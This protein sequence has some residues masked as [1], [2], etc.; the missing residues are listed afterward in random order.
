ML[1]KL[2]DLYT[3]AGK[4]A[5]VLLVF[6]ITLVITFEIGIG[7]VAGVLIRNL[8]QEIFN[9]NESFF[10]SFI[11]IFP[12]MIAPLLIDFFWDDIKMFFKTKRKKKR[13]IKKK[14]VEKSL[15]TLKE[16]VAGW[17]TSTFGITPHLD[18]YISLP[19]RLK[20]IMSQK[21]H[22]YS[23]YVRFIRVSENDKWVR[24]FNKYYPLD[25]IYGYN[26]TS[27]ELYFIDGYVVK[28]PALASKGR[29]NRFI[30]L[31]F[32]ERGY[33]YDNLPSVSKESF[34]KIVADGINT[35]EKVDWAGLR[36]KWEQAIAREKDIRGAK[37][38]SANGYHPLTHGGKL[39]RDYYTRALSQAEI[40]RTADIFRNGN[41]SVTELTSFDE[42]VNEY[43][44]CNGVKILG[45]LGY[46]QNA[47]GIDFLFNCLKDVDEA[48]FMPA[49]D[50]LSGI[51]LNTLAPIIEE[52]AREAYKK[53]DV[54][55]LAGILYLAKN[56]NYEIEY[57]KELK[58]KIKAQEEPDM[59]FVDENGIVRFD[60][61]QG[62]QSMQKEVVAFRQQ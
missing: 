2:S 10:V 57:V 5:Q 37:K 31:F 39:R 38:G 20:V 28:L 46:P 55:R 9:I 17:Y 14:T 45:E 58:E 19:E 3:E 43:C 13:K 40:K 49:V 53:C 21:F 22:P 60:P 42:Y 8:I 56:I 62:D 25:L 34:D 23:K 54:L 26:N 18:K 7:T 4:V 15:F 36:Y 61:E 29:Y 11:V 6:P 1:K 33:T 32:N 35:F 30:D 41:F 52:K 16:E 27:N 50:V 47:K 59:T 12:F 51:P 48:Y 24:I 44:V